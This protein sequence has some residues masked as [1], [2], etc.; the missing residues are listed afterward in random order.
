M[1]LMAP[2]WALLGGLLGGFLGGVRALVVGAGV[3]TLAYWILRTGELSARAGF[4][5]A[6]FAAWAPCLLLFLG[7]YLIARRL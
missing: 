4:G 7:V 3:V 2:L 6:A 1:P 5:S